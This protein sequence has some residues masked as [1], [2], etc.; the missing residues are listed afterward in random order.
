[1]YQEMR[2]PGIPYKAHI[3]VFNFQLARNDLRLYWKQSSKN[4]AQNC[5]DVCQGG[6][7]KDIQLWSR[8]EKDR[9]RAN[10]EKVKYRRVRNEE[11]DKDTDGEQ[12]QKEGEINTHIEGE[13]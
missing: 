5:K 10:T 1:M 11:T 6:V 4:F 12:R 8:R 2:V 9:G 3:V 7:D 13:R